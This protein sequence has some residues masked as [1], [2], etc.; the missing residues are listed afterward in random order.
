M[1]GFLIFPGVKCLFDND[2]LLLLDDVLLNLLFNRISS[3]SVSLRS[4]RILF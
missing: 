1:D 4:S 3:A 2:E